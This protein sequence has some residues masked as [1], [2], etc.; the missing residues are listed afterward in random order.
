MQH[1]FY[2]YTPIFLTYFACNVIIFI[3][4]FCDLFTCEILH[5]HTPSGGRSTGVDRVA[6]F[7]AT[8]TL[9]HFC[10]NL[11]LSCFCDNQCDL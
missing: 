8:P 9:S 7:Y 2:G 3:V 5:P 10:A 4:N 1:K 11:K 6:H